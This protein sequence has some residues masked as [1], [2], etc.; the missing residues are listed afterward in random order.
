M[1]LHAKTQTGLTLIELLVSLAIVSFTLIGVS[2]FLYQVATATHTYDQNTEKLLTI[3]HA[4][5]RIQQDMNNI[6]SVLNTSSGSQL[7]ITTPLG[8]ITYTL[9]GNNIERSLNSGTA[10]VLFKGVTST[11]FN[12]N[13]YDANG[14]PLNPATQTNDIDYVKST[15]VFTTNGPAITVYNIGFVG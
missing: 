2:R 5:A 9:N 11:S 3:Q 1:P 6:T 12:F 14:T 8:N 7:D 10:R 13:Y 15:I 4:Q